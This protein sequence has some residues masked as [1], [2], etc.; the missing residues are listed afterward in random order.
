MNT[1]LRTLG[2]G[3]MLACAS[4]CGILDD[5][6]ERAQ[7]AQVVVNGTSPVPLSLIT[8][9]EFVLETDPETLVT[10]AVLIVSDTAEFTPPFEDI[11]QIDQFERFL[12]R[13]VNPD[14]AVASIRMQVLVDGSLEYDQS[15]DVAEGGSLE[16]TFQVNRFF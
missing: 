8:S 16:F 4:A 15:A 1:A 3:L 10:T 2:A 12:V 14:S 9:S 13:L 5:Q 7:R 6:E 11:Y